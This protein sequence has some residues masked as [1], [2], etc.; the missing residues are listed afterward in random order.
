ME[1][2]TVYF[3]FYEDVKVARG[4]AYCLSHGISFDVR[5]G[6]VQF[7]NSL[8][9]QRFLRW[10]KIRRRYSRD[11]ERDKNFY[12]WPDDYLTDSYF[13]PTTDFS[14]NV[15]FIRF[16][17]SWDISFQTT[18]RSI[19]F[20]SVAHYLRQEIQRVFGTQF[21]RHIKSY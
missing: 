20:F 21:L 18:G 8:D 5:P 17:I 13:R 7:D 14:L 16:L 11:M 2:T 4:L 6:G 9:M 10:S 1:N 3:E 15:E 12:N 19:I